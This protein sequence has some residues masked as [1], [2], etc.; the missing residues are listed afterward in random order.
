MGTGSVIRWTRQNHNQ[1]VAPG[2]KKIQKNAKL[3][4][5]T[6][7]KSKSTWKLKFISLIIDSIKSSI[8]KFQ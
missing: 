7:H 1:K 5:I 6:Y 8:I 4:M 2:K 3:S